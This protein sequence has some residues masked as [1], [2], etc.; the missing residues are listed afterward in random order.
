MARR[1]R[2]DCRQVRKVK[3]SKG[4]W[5]F[6][7]RGTPKTHPIIATL[8]LNLRDSG[9]VQRRVLGPDATLSKDVVQKTLLGAYIKNPKGDGT[10]FISGVT[11]P[12]LAKLSNRS[13]VVTLYERTVYSSKAIKGTRPKMLFTGDAFE[14]DLCGSLIERMR[15]TDWQVDQE[16]VDILKVRPPYAY[17]LTIPSAYSPRLF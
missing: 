4:S 9:S 6:T 15:T 16:F 8:T 17:L 11:V 5:I 12:G 1:S 14:F 3:V 10:T 13:S 2:Q 7:Q